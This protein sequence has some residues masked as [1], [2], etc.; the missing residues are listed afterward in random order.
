MTGQRPLLVSG[1]ADIIDD[2]LRL[3]SA[4]GV[5]I[6]LATDAEAARSR[7]QLAPLVLVGADFGAAVAAARMSRRR[8]VVLIAREPTPECWQNAV[9]LGAEHVV[10]LPDA[11]RW[12]IDRLADSGEGPTRDGRIVSVMGCGGGAGASTFAVTMA[13]AAAGRSLR[14][15]LIDGDPLGGGLDL[16]LGM[17]EAPGI[18]WAELAESRG[19]LG[20]Q[21]LQQAVPCVEGVSVL[22]WGRGGPTS[23]S[24]EAVT[25]VL[26]AGVRAFDLVV[27]DLARHFD[28]ST[29]LV[30]SRADATLVVV[31]N[32]VRSVAAASRLLTQLE[33]RC[34]TPHLV[35]RED[36]KGLGED[37]VTAALGMPI[38][39]RLPT[40]TALPAWADEG[41]LPAVR[42]G[43][44]RA[45]MDAL[46]LVAP[47]RE[48]A[49]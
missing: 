31:A 14:V 1:D 35:L 26:D 7:W 11:E 28:V 17:E 27:V 34:A 12:L 3:A 47:Q 33:G 38:A 10:S 5:E 23:L 18:R 15:L 46:G 19:R 8:D 48:R 36:D 45:C 32:R 13:L 4:H 40:Q 9:A 24:M 21:S 6:H 20:A 37:A 29:E 2:V 39:S 43:Y 22:S 42:D 49:A 16:V 41:R 44:G 30:L 25:A